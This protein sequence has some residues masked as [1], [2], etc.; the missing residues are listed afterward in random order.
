MK[1][2]RKMLG[3]ESAISVTEQRHPSPLFYVQEKEAQA[4]LGRWAHTKFL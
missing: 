1:G 3:H 2:R 4:V